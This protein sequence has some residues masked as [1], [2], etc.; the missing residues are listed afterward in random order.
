MSRNS[1]IVS[2]SQRCSGIGRGQ[3]GV[4]VNLI[5]IILFAVMVLG[6]RRWLKRQPGA[7]AGAVRVPRG[8]INGFGSKWKRGSGRWVRDVFVWSK[9]PFLFRTE[10]VAVDMLSGERAADAGE[11][12]RLGEKPTPT[13][14]G[15]RPTTSRKNS[16]TSSTNC[17]DSS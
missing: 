1:R 8:A 17:N 9:A 10:L 16:P 12:K 3:L 14:T 4:G 2:A 11:V 13:P 15:P 6:R 5:V 7:F